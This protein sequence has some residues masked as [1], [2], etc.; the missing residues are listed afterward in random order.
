MHLKLLEKKVIQKKAAA[1]GGLLLI[2]LQESQE[3]H[4]RIVQR[5]LQMKQKHQK[6]YD[7]FS[8]K[9]QKIINHLRLI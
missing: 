8:R 6:K 5:H 3:L 2:K 7:G 4:Q 9:K 1:T